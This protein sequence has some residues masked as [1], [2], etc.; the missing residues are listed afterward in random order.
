ML[1]IEIVKNK[2]RPVFMHLHYYRQLQHIGIHNDFEN[3]YSAFER[4][5]YRSFDDHNDALKNDPVLL[6]RDF[7]INNK[8]FIEEEIV[9][10]ERQIKSEI[11]NAIITAKK[12]NLSNPDS[13]LNHVI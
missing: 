11:D 1:G 6:F 7:L 3:N 10:L 12:A 9:N 5:N 8:N 13:L 2:N 4:L